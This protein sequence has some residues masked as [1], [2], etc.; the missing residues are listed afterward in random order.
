MIEGAER[1]I[2]REVRKGV[3]DGKGKDTVMLAMKELDRSKGRTVRSSEWAQE[4]GLW[5]FH[6]QIYVPMVPDL[7]HRI[8]EQHHNSKIGGTPDVGRCSN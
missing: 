8:T 7:R 4:N 2:L 3:R 6:D 1:E 5:R